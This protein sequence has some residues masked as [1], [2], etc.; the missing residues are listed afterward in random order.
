M[1]TTDAPV[2]GMQTAAGLGQG[3]RSPR[4]QW[5]HARD[6]VTRQHP[7][8]IQGL[9]ADLEG[10]RILHLSDLHVKT[11]WS[12]AY[13]ALIAQTLARQYD[14]ILVTGDLVDDKRDHRPA[15]PTLCKFL[16]QLRTR[17]GIWTILGNHDNVRMGMELE[18]VGIP[19][20][21]GER[22]V[23]QVGSGRVELIGAPGPERRHLRASFPKRFGPPD[24]GVPRI[25][26]AHFP[27]HFPKLVCMEP[28]LYLC[29]HTHGGQ[30]CLPNGFAPFLHDKSPRHLCKGIHRMGKT[31]YVVNQGFG[32]S[33][34][35]I[36]VFCPAEVVEITLSGEDRTA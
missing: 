13:D 34:L 31:H 15:M 2:I 35:P 8:H 12:C 33:G 14:L 19:V 9:S 17:L 6:F 29:G 23:V 16:S 18:N 28:D 30:I 25:I 26:M 22:Q 24:A 32:F 20:L 21:L 4:L 10:L 3:L 5:L 27:D 36:R 11:K 7:A 1:R